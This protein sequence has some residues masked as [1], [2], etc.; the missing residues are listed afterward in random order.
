MPWYLRD[1]TGV[2]YW[3]HVQTPSEPLVIANENQEGELQPLLA[4]RYTLVGTYPLRPGVTLQLYARNDI[5]H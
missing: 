5:G 4:G 1:Y 2:G 3:G